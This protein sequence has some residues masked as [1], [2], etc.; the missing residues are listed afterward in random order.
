MARPIWTGT[1]SFGLLNVPVSLMSGERK[2]DLSFR[3]L[4]SRDRKPI[5]YERVNAETGEEV[6]WKDVVKAF[7]YDKGSYVVVEEQDIKSA[8]PESHETV[9]VET[10]VDAGMIPPQFFEKPYVLVPAKKAEKGYVLLRETLKATKQ[11]GIARVV[12]RTREYLAAVMPQDDAL[13]LMLLRYP[14]ELVDPAD[15]KLPEGK[16][17]TYRITAKEMDMAKQLIGSMSGKWV[18]DDYH[19]EFRARLEAVI[20]K[21]MKSKGALAKAE[22]NEPEAAEDTATNVVDFMSLLQKSIASNK[23]TPAKKGA[24]KKTARKT[25]KK[26][27]PVKKAPVKKKTATAAGKSAK[28]RTG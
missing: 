25:A 3:M 12:I 11:V 28:R 19:D 17:S 14:Q 18:P 9:E 27:A 13:L 2:V 16:P 15:Y 1:L 20:K 6:P 21:K 24:A 10:F 4:D 23:R 22:D 7:E 5:R 8:A 26:K